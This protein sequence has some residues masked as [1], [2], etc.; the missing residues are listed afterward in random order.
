MESAWPPVAAFHASSPAM[1]AMQA[2]TQATGTLSAPMRSPLSLVVMPVP[3]IV[4]Y[5]STSAVPLSKAPSPKMAGRMSTT[6]S[7][8]RGWAA[9]KTSSSRISAILSVWS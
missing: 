1:T 2:S 3:V 6:S 5:E 7:L 9:A 8:V 4:L